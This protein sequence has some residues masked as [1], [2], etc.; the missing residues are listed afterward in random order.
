MPSSASCVAGRRWDQPSHVRVAHGRV[1]VGRLQ[2]SRRGRAQL[3]SLMWRLLARGGGDAWLHRMCPRH[4]PTA[5]WSLLPYIAPFLVADKAAVRPALN[6][7]ATEK[8]NGMRPW[9]DG[10]GHVVWPASSSS[11]ASTPDPGK[12]AA[13]LRRQLKQTGARITT[14]DKRVHSYPS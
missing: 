1:R 14:Q 5:S 9:R 6:P 13:R 4:R 2:G 7:T 8:R 11:P 10:A 3:D 12:S